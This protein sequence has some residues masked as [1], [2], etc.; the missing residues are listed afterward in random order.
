MFC[1]FK[2]FSNLFIYLNVRYFGS[3]RIK[4]SRY[5]LDVSIQLYTILI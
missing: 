4:Y 3:S 5:G 1:L 2:K